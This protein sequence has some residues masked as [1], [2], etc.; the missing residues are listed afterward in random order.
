ME[1]W[2]HGFPRMAPSFW[3]SGEASDDSN[4][5]PERVFARA[6]EAGATE[7]FPVGE[8]HGWRLGR[9]VDRLGIIGR[10]GVRFGLEALVF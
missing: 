3:L 1:A 9:V 8:A 10:L 7:I 2:W 5:S 4:G 6:I